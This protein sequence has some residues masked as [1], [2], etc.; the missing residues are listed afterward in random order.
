M[1]HFLINS[2]S[3]LLH[4]V[5]VENLFFSF[6]FIYSNLFPIGFA[7]ARSKDSCESYLLFLLYVIKIFMLL[8][9]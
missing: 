7:D 6:L 1:L 9:I 8:I 5:L 2:L 3:I 4:Q